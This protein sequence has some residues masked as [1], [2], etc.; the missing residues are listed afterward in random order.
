MDT[1]HHIQVIEA[2]GTRVLA[3]TRRGTRNSDD[4]SPIIPVV[5]AHPPCVAHTSSPRP[6]TVSSPLTEIIKDVSSALLERSPHRR[7]PRPRVPDRR[8]TGLHPSSV[9][10]RVAVVILP[11]IDTPACQCLCI[12]GLVSLGPGV[13]RA[14]HLA[15]APIK[16]E[17]QTHAVNLVCHGLDA[18]GPLG[19][20]WNEVSRRVTRLG[21]PAV[22]DN[23][24][25]V[26]QIL[27]A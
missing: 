14:C 15:S 17:L 25:L 16:P 12:L 2:P 18:V 5:C 20:V 4:T 27:E 21:A 26:A 9:A 7:H 24:V 11:V 22:I 10:R 19:R 23:D 1:Y 3:D 6:N 8:R 13:S